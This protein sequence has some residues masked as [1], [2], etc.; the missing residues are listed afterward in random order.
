MFKI[1]QR[2]WDKHMEHNVLKFLV[3]FKLVCCDKDFVRGFAGC[4]W[5][6]IQETHAVTQL[7]GVQTLVV[8][9]S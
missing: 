2:L 8:S 7:L 1:L 3:V 9:S 5:L 4:Y 6:A